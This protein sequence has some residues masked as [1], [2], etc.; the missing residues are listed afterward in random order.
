MEQT[1]FPIPAVKC[2]ESLQTSASARSQLFD[3][4]RNV[5][6]ASAI[7]MIAYTAQ[8]VEH[9]VQTN[10]SLHDIGIFVACRA[11]KHKGPEPTK[12]PTFILRNSLSELRKTGR[13]SSEPRS[14][15]LDG[16]NQNLHFKDLR[17]P[18]QIPPPRLSD[19]TQN[20][21]LS[22]ISNENELPRPQ[23]GQSLPAQSRITPVSQQPDPGKLE[24]ENPQAAQI[25]PEQQQAS[26][27]ESSYSIPIPVATQCLKLLLD[28]S[29]FS[30]HRHIFQSDR[31]PNWEP[32]LLW[33]HLKKY[34]KLSRKREILEELHLSHQLRQL[35]RKI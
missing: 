14:S 16:Q 10:N 25:Q 20:S 1:S 32:S 33:M 19:P 23:T 15:H 11:L 21:R 31:L 13:T 9:A 12:D 3:H 7:S 4:P 27:K 2:V 5:S 6:L 35:Q 8:F 34:S 28:G 22:Q 18:P 26:P 17:E 30:S 29:G 24:L